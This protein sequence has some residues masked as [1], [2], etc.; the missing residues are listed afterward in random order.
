LKKYNEE[1]AEEGATKSNRRKAKGTA[2]HEFYFRR[3]QPDSEIAAED[4]V[5]H[6]ETT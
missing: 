6:Y 1:A 3:T 5:K 4:F 2:H